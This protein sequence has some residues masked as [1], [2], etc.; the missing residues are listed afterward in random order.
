M[1][2]FTLQIKAIKNIYKHH[3]QFVQVVKARESLIFNNLQLVVSNRPTFK[4]KGKYKKINNKC[5]RHVLAQ[6]GTFLNSISL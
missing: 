4:K 5:D 6:S 2:C 1:L 3:L